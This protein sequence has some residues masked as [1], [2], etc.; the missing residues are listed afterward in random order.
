VVLEDASAAEAG[1][2][3]AEWIVPVEW[4]ATRKREEAI[5]D[6]DFSANQN[7]AVKLT[8]GYTLDR[9]VRAFDLEHA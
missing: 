7:S 4:L 2:P 9:L 3:L 5:K 1:P 6:S 8:H